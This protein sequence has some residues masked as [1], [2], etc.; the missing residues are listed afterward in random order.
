MSGVRVPHHPPAGAGR[1]AVRGV[2]DP[3][4]GS[5]DIKAF[6]ERV[7]GAPSRLAVW[8]AMYAFLQARGFDNVIYLRLG[9]LADPGPGWIDVLAEGVPDE[10]TKAYVAE[11]LWRADPVTA[12][13]R[14]S[15]APFFWLDV[16][17]MRKLSPPE[18]SFLRR[19]VQEALGDGV[20]LPVFGPALRDGYVGAGFGG[21][22]RPLSAAAL[23]ELQCAAQMGHLAYCGVAPAGGPQPNSLSPRERE[24]MGW[25]ARGRSNATIGEI[26]GVSFHTVDTMVRRI[27]AK[28]DV[29]DRTT[30]T[31]RALACGEIGLREVLD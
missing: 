5:G 1:V 27:F 30:A 28:L 21:A 14:V 29:T 19:R 9:P 12:Q 26:L 31:V 23:R 20:A 4:S 11:E 22:R 10:W 13:A 17:Q 25:I 6:V 3:V 24:V 15:L 2:I 16:G 7:A 18:A 8:R